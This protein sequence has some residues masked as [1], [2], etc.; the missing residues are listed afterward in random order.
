[1]K[2]IMMLQLSRKR[3]GIQSGVIRAIVCAGLLFVAAHD[4]PALAT[5]IDRDSDRF[6]QTLEFSSPAVGDAFSLTALSCLRRHAECQQEA[7]E[8]NNDCRDECSEMYQPDEPEFQ[9]CIQ[10]CGAIWGN[11]REM[12]RAA[13]N[14]CKLCMLFPMLCAQ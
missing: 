10:A 12:C 3:W 8:H 2:K 4:S 6:I 11:E 13:Y 14:V 9:E 5:G 7:V 1:M